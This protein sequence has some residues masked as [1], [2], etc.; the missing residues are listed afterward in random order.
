M[1]G[2]LQKG[3]IID[4]EHVTLGGLGGDSVQLDIVDL[5]P[6]AERVD[7]R[8]FLEAAG[9]DAQDWRI[10]RSPVGDEED[11][12]GHFGSVAEL[13]SESIVHHPSDSKTGIR[14]TT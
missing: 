11:F 5:L 3:E 2:S 10:A 6:D 12:V 8:L 4:V 1:K 9:F 14:P 7:R 13:R